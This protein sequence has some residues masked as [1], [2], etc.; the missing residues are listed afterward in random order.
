MGTIKVNSDD[1]IEIQEN[2]SNGTRE[3]QSSTSIMSADDSIQIYL[4]NIS[5]YHLL[6]ADEEAELSKDIKSNDKDK[7]KIAIEKLINAN[8]RLVVSI[9]K[10]YVGR[11]LTLMDLIQEGNI[12][13]MRAAER[14]DYTKGNKFS[15]YATYWITQSIYRAII[16]KSRLIRLPVHMVEMLTKIK[17]ASVELIYENNAV[18]TTEEISYKLNISADKINHLLEMEQGPISIDAPASSKDMTLTFEDFIIDDSA[19][20]PDEIACD[21]NISE[22]I[23]I[24]LDKLQPKER[25]IITMRYGL[26]IEKMTLTEIAQAYGLSKERVRQIENKALSKLRRFCNDEDINPTLKENLKAYIL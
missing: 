7:K 1:D 6:T 23:K 5:R 22:D 11:G 12:G 17:R 8:L 3:E 2:K 16:D 10:K 14:F 4:N 19:T 26:G 20:T 15:T 18:P 13:L 24:M 9:A 21:R 25:D